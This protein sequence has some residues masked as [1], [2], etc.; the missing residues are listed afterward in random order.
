MAGVNNDELPD[1]VEKFWNRDLD[2]RFIEFMPFL[3]NGW[4]KGKLL[5]YKTMRAILDE[6]FTLVPRLGEQSD[7]AQEFDVI[8]GSVRIGFITSMTESFCGGC[9]RIRLTADG[10]LKVCLFAKTGPSLRDAMRSGATDD[11]LE[12][13]IRDAL[14]GKWAAHPPMERLVQVND[15]PMISIGG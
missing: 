10:R 5:P 14:Y 11:E 13:L 9:N 8:G 15:L 6:R 1:F 12:T 4:Q 2:I 7:V 3:S